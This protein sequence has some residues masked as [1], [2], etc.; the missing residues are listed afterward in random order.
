M[1]AEVDRESNLLEGD[2]TG[3]LSRLSEMTKEEETPKNTS[4]INEIFKRKFLPS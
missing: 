3:V 4:F 2:R 1:I